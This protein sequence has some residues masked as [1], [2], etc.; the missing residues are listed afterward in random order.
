MLLIEIVAG[1]SA[2]VIRQ[3]INEKQWREELN[4]NLA[5]H[6]AFPYEEVKK[7]LVL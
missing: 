1:I 6:N 5:L 3:Q 2:D 4:K 7:I